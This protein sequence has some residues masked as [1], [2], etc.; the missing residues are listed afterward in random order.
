MTPRA[1]H[2]PASR[3]ARPDGVEIVPVEI[4]GFASEAVYHAPSL[5]GARRHTQSG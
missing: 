4:D 3:A 1:T 2:T 5:M